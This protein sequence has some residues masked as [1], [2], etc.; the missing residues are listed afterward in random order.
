MRKIKRKRKGTSMTTTAKCVQCH[1]AAYQKV[2]DADMLFVGS[3]ASVVESVVCSANGPRVLA[4]VAGSGGPGR[5]QTVDY[6][7]YPCHG[8]GGSSMIVNFACGEWECSGTHRPTAPPIFAI[9]P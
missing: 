1:S 3:F 6:S 7:C 8:L 4:G 5:V 2:L 9:C